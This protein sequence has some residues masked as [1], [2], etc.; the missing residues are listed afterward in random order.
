MGRIY[1]KTEAA[2]QP[3]RVSPRETH[4]EMESSGA[5]CLHGD[6]LPLSV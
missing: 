4:L 6:V 2:R 5:G 3:L 1:A